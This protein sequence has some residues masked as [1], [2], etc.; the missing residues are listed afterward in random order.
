MTAKNGQHLE[1]AGTRRQGLA[2]RHRNLYNADTC[3]YFYN[4]EKWQPE[5][6]PYTA[7]AVHRY[8][9]TLAD[10]G[11]DTFLINANAQRAWYPSKVIPGILDGY[12]RGDRDYFRGHA[13]CQGI[14]D[15]QETEA[16][17]DRMIAFMN[18]YQDLL[19][20]GVDWLA[21]T[22]QACRRRGISP[23]V[24][25]RMNDMHGFNNPEG[26]FFNLP[27]FKEE[28]FRLKNSAYS[29]TMRNP[30]YRR[31]LNYE[32]PEVR[33]LMFAQIREVVE[34]Y[35]FEGLELDWLRNPLCCEP[36]ASAETVAMMTD[37]F[38]GI[39]ELTRRREEATGKPFPLGMRIPYNLNTLLSIGIDVRTLVREGIV[40]FLAPSFFWR[41]SW[42]M[43][44]DDLKAE[45]GNGVTIYGV[46]EDG[47]NAL[48][49]YA[50]ELDRTMEIRYISASRPIL[51]ANAAGKLVLGAEGIYWFNFYCTDQPRIPG[52][53]SHYPNLRN[54]EPLQPLRGEPKHYV[55]GNQSGL[56][57]HIPFETPPQVPAILEP[58]WR[59]A[60]RMPMCAEP[61][62][63]GL[64]LVVQLVVQADEECRFVPVMF[65]GC[66]P[67]LENERTERLLF[68]CG[69]LTHHV[70]AH[71]GFNY[72]FPVSLVRDGWNEVVVENGGE[73]PLRLVCIE[74]AVRRRE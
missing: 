53:T 73:Q 62:E 9:D 36:N 68:P 12:V 30:D 65:N 35:D 20:A 25:I 22:H 57:S 58:G 34:D 72:T 2:D 47:A 40:D 45:L 61:A 10:N 74:L 64:E 11:I 41:T 3:V 60:F 29:P 51:A 7:K 49:T 56:L 33:D 48:P 18:L 23:W 13:V 52:L 55:F 38:R 69:P 46:I 19:D 8:V 32:C 37:W 42:D 24:S 70:P 54:I 50:P 14:T 71:A 5:G 15:P 6:G 66:W 1:P 59:Q 17:V 16:F 26:S 39:R 31:G 4:P 67:K 28:R 27:L 63:A 44:H 43:P 21:E